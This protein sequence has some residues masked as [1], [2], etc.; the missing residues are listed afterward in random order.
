MVEQA[1]VDDYSRGKADFYGAG[2]RSIVSNKL[3][4]V[5]SHC[6]Q[7]DH[8]KCAT[9]ESRVAPESTVSYGYYCLADLQSPTFLPAAV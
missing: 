9:V 3:H 8:L 6:C 7:V 1:T 2:Y 5:E 4:V